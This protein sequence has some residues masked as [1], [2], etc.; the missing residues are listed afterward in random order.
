MKTCVNISAMSWPTMKVAKATRHSRYNP[1]YVSRLGLA[2]VAI[3]HKPEVTLV[4]PGV[5]R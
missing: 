4:V 3:G 5:S 1:G 2:T